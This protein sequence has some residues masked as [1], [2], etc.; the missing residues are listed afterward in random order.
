MLASNPGVQSYVL[1]DRRGETTSLKPQAALVK[2][3]FEA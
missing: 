2:P 3:G 1:A